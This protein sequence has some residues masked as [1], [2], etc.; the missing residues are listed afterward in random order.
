MD[1]DSDFYQDDN[2]ELQDEIERSEDPSLVVESNERVPSQQNDNQ[3][4]LVGKLNW[5]SS[6]IQSSLPNVSW[7]QSLSDGKSICYFEVDR[8]GKKER[9]SPIE[10]F[11]EYEIYELNGKY[12]FKRIGDA[13]SVNLNELLKDM[14]IGF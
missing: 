10:G 11:G 7:T 4:K 6:N 13:K 2:Q 3:R 14:G 1:T 5:S 9:Y 8:K 12:E